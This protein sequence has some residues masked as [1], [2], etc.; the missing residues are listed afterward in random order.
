MEPWDDLAAQMARR[1]RLSRNTIAEIND[2]EAL[3][4]VS[5]A[6][7]LIHRDFTSRWINRVVG[8][9][10]FSYSIAPWMGNLAKTCPVTRL[11]AGSVL[12]LQAQKRSAQRAFWGWRGLVMIFPGRAMGAHEDCL[13]T[14]Y[15]VKTPMAFII[16]NR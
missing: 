12:L 4:A 8:K 9:P 15:Y 2:L 7:H 13:V 11:L 5:K 3:G 14:Y 16:E 1:K 10:D 6:F